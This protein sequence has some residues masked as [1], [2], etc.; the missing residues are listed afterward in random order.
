MS[1][2]RLTENQIK[3]LLANKNVENC[4][5]RSITYN[6]E[7]KVQAVNKYYQNGYSP[8]MIFK[9]AGFDISVI[10]EDTPGFSLQRW[11]KE[12]QERGIDSLKFERRGQLG[13]GGRVKTKEL[14]NADRIK[15]LEIENAYLKAE[16]YFL[17]KLRAAQK[18]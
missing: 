18:R 12:Y 17:A 16:N 10:G 13:R 4:S 5:D 9:E 1:K 2:R 7:F 14:N 8:R 6:K 11:R 15:R 3:E